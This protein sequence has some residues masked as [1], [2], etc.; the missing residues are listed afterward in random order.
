MVGSGKLY[1]LK[2]PAVLDR[3]PATAYGYMVDLLTC[4]TAIEILSLEN[5]LSIMWHQ[6]EF[7]F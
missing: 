5:V 3:S 1:A 6:L 7:H 2:D 4:T